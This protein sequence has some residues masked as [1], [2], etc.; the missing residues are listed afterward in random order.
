MLAWMQPHCFFSDEVDLETLMMAEKLSILVIGQDVLRTNGEVGSQCTIL[1]DNYCEDAYDLLQT[2][3]L[4]KLLLAGILLDTQNLNASDKSSMTRDSEA[5]QLLL[6]G[7]AT[8]YRY[9]LFDQHQ[10]DESFLEALRHNYG[11]RPTESDF[12]S[13][14]HVEHKLIER[15]STSISQDKDIMHNPYKNPSNVR[16]SKTNRVSPK[17]AKPNSSSVQSAQAAPAQTASEAARAK[18]KFFLAKWFGFG[19]KNENK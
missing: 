18:P 7:S 5:V 19:S 1:T 4:K 17:S 10:R 14:T 11:K 3:A 8:N 13:M 15:K 9:A 2:P 6:V 16:S 12:D